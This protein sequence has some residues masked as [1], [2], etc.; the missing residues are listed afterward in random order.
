MLAAIKH[1]LAI[2]KSSGIRVYSYLLSIPP[3]SVETERTFPLPACCAPKLDH[4]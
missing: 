2:F 3:A 1:E 4:D